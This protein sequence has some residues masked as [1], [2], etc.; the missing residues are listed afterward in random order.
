MKVVMA[1]S[2]RYVI[3]ECEKFVPPFV[4]LGE[5]V[6]DLDG[7][8][9]SLSHRHRKIFPKRDLEGMMTVGI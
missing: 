4:C 7:Q 9:Q 3:E 2:C 1:G 5:D 6:D 8:A